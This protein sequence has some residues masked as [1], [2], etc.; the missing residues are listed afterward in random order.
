M[1]QSPEHAAR[2]LGLIGEPTLEEVK[3]A[4][5]ELAMKY[6][7]DR[8]DDTGR[9]TRRMARV[10]AAADTLTVYLKGKS[11]PQSDKQASREQSADNTRTSERSEHFEQKRQTA[12]APKPKPKQ[13]RQRAARSVGTKTVSDTAR[14]AW[15][16]ERALAARA[17]ASYRAVLD[18]IGR[19]APRAR[20]DF[21]ILQFDTPGI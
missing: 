15:K 14:R 8:S 11:A 13:S 18:G 2:V 5:R 3:R 9:A 19:S 17:A 16:S 12:E 6:H 10:N 4:R 20:V 7:P 21:H 1:A